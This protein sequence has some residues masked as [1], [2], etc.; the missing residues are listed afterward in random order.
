VLM[1]VAVIQSGVVM[2]GQLI[3]DIAYVTVDPRIDFT[4]SN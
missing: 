4:G 1:A 3:S 2:I